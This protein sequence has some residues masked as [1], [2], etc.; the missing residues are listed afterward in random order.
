VNQD[1]DF[2]SGALGEQGKTKNEQQWN[3]SAHG[4]LPD[5]WL[6]MDERRWCLLRWSWKLDFAELSRIREVLINGHF[7]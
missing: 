4:F 6:K 2:G 1:N 5:G 3:E 7:E